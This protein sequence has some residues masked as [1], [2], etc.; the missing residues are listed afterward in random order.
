MTGSTKTKKTKIK[1][2]KNKIIPLKK[3]V[4]KMKEVIPPYA[5]L[6]EEQFDDLKSFVLW[7]NPMTDLSVITSDSEISVIEMSFN[8]GKIHKSF[9]SMFEKMNAILDAITPDDSTDSDEEEY[10]EEEGWISYDGDD[11]ENN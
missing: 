1:K 7:D 4:P 6:T 11:E 2:T 10:E 8:L 3:A 9:E 5:V